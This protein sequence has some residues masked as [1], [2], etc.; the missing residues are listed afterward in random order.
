[1]DSARAANPRVRVGDAVDAFA[2]KVTR[3]LAAVDSAG[4]G[5][6]TLAEAR[7][8]TDLSLRSRVLDVR[9]ALLSG[10]VSGLPK[11]AEVMSALEPSLGTNSPRVRGEIEV[12]NESGDNGVNTFATPLPGDRSVACGAEGCEP[13]PAWLASSS[14]TA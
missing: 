4:K 13:A 11:A 14:F 10:D 1:M 8:I 12:F 7:R 2:R 6:L 3:A 5:T 9:A